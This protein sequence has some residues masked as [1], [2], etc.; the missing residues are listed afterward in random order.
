M[1]RFRTNFPLN[2]NTNTS[3]AGAVPLHALVPYVSVQNTNDFQSIFQL[4]ATNFL[5]PYIGF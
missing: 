3:E 2:P 5:S 4:S 1:K